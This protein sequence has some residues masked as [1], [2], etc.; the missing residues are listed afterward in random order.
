MVRRHA[1]RFSL[2]PQAP[3]RRRVLRLLTACLAAMMLPGAVLA[4]G[5]Q[6]SAWEKST[7]IE[8]A[9]DAAK[10]IA[11][12]PACAAVVENISRRVATIKALKAALLKAEM[13][14]PTSVK[15]ALQGLFGKAEPTA[16]MIA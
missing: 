11:A 13:G 4:A 12:N 6:P 16:S 10:S 15:S 3:V 1:S 8:S 7:R 5:N 14:P 9:D 2:A